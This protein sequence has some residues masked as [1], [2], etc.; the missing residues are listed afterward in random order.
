LS[1]RRV[2]MSRDVRSRLLMLSRSGGDP[3]RR[4][5]DVGHQEP[6]VDPHDRTLNTRFA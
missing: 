1:G 3:H 2:R 4:S 6:M 5:E